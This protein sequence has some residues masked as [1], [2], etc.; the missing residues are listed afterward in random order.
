MQTAT[1]GSQEGA[2]EN[3]RINYSGDQG[4]TIRQ[5]ITSH[6]LRRIGMCCLTSPHGRR[7]HLAVCNEKG[8]V[9][10][11]QLSALLKQAHSSKR[12]LTLTVR[13]VCWPWLL[14]EELFSDF[15]WAELCRYEAV[16]LVINSVRAAFKFSAYHSILLASL[17]VGHLLLLGWPCIYVRITRVTGEVFWRNCIIDAI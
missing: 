4:Q 10:I 9:T 5:L 8:K 12:K 6:V 15:D 11:L 7:Q 2:F 16:Q 14:L 1:L 3:V 17:L 13:F